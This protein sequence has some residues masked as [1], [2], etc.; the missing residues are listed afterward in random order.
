MTELEKHLNIPLTRMVLLKFDG[1]SYRYQAWTYTEDH[2]LKYD[3]FFFYLLK[4]KKR[5]FY[6]KIWY[7]IFS[8]NFSS[9]ET[10]FTHTVNRNEQVSQTLHYTQGRTKNPKINVKIIKNAKYKKH[11]VSTRSKRINY[12][13]IAEQKTNSPTLQLLYRLPSWDYMDGEPASSKA[14]QASF[15]SVNRARANASFSVPTCL[16]GCITKHALR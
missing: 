11:F 10:I 14:D 3:T 5:L 12:K 15:S 16:S 6:F 8:E 4:Y 1:N 9:P 13:Y 7:K 2:T